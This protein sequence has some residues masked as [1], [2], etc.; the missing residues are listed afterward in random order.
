MKL[1]DKDNEM[2]LPFRKWTYIFAAYIILSAAFMSQVFDFLEKN[3][4]RQF[5]I[6]VF[7]VLF[8]GLFF[9]FFKEFKKYKYFPISK[10]MF[11]LVVFAIGIIYAIRLEYMSEKLHLFYYGVLGWMSAG[12]GIEFFYKRK[13]LK[14]W[15]LALLWVGLIGY[16]DELFQMV[17]PYRVYDIRDIYTNIFSGLWGIS[18]FFIV[19]K[20]A[21]P[22]A[23]DI[24]IELD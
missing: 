4:G 23:W 12:D 9:I 19:V 1:I 3:L 14:T 22:P 8:I 6:G 11:F 15:I 21:P 20:I 10:F 18:I 17:L 7:F 13:K 16:L 24:D 2:I 5:I